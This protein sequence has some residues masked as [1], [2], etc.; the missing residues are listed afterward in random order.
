MPDHFLFLP[1]PQGNVMAGDLKF[2]MQE[3]TDDAAPDSAPMTIDDWVVGRRRRP[4]RA[5]VRIVLASIAFP[6][7]FVWGEF[8]SVGSIDFPAVRQYFAP[9]RPVDHPAA[10]ARISCSPAASWRM[11]AGCHGPQTS[12]CTSQTSNVQT[13]VISGALDIWRPRRRMRQIS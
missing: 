10:P 13:L 2:G 12:T 1:I 11:L 3:S 6:Q 4:E 9:P 8:A 5:L 7:S